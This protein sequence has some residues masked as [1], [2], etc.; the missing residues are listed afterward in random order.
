[1]ECEPGAGG[2][3]GLRPGARH[4]R[5]R[6]ETAGGKGTWVFRIVL[7]HSRKAYAEAVHR[8]THR[9]FSALSGERLRLLR[10]GAQ[11]AGHRQSSRG[12]EPGGLVRSG[13]VSQG[14]ARF[15][16]HYGIADP[17]DQPVHAAAQGEDRSGG[18]GYVKSNALKGR[19]FASLAEQNRHLLEWETQVADTAHPRHDAPAGEG[20]LRA[21]GEAGAAAAAGLPVRSVP[22]SV[23][24]RASGRAR[25][26]QGRLLLGAAGVFGPAALGAVG[27]PDWCGCSIRRCSPIAVHAQRPPGAFST[28]AAHIAPEKISGIEKGTGWLLRRVESHRPA[29]RALGGIDAAIPRHRRAC[30]C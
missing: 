3:G 4:R 14:R 27:R 11:N 2:A 5:L 26:D 17:A 28:L 6:I 7:S 13:A 9:R 8:Q 25:G 23:A 22:G 18:I 1:M 29:R 24:E 21:G 12:G 16:E 30:A 10:R 19:T 15:A 20:S